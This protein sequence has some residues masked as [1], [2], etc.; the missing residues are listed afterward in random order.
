MIT[1]SLKRSD[2]NNEAFKYRDQL[3]LQNECTVST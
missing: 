1:V 3:K 2:K